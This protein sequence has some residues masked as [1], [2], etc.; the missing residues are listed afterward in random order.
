MEENLVKKIDVFSGVSVY[1]IE[2]DFLSMTADI[3]K[4]RFKESIQKP[5]QLLLNE[6]NR[7]PRVAMQSLLQAS[8]LGLI[9]GLADYYKKLL[10]N[11]AEQTKMN[12]REHYGSS[13]SRQVCFIDF[14]SVS[15]IRKACLAIIDNDRSAP[16][17]LSRRS[18]DE[19]ESTFT[20]PAFVSQLSTL[21]RAQPGFTF[22]VL[23]C[24]KIAELAP[25]N[26]PDT[27]LEPK[28]VK[29]N[30]EAGLSDILRLF[31]TKIWIAR[32]CYI[33]TPLWLNL[34]YYLIYMKRVLYA[35][36]QALWK[37]SKSVIDV[38]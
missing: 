23:V 20:G 22:P 37:N 11:S 15:K 32:V 6:F 12:L 3:F 25:T 9:S 16:T 10:S 31:R 29:L 34:I 1:I 35:K 7:N 4:K 26:C 24:W 33:L 8:I 17:L 2:W 38:E 27:F 5:L 14:R 30:S 21:R 18:L 19:M 36:A 13:T 28:I